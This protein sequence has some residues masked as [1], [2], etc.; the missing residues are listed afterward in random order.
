MAPLATPLPLSQGAPPS[1]NPIAAVGTIADDLRDAVRGLV[2]A[3][4]DPAYDEVR[5]AHHVIVDQRPAAV[6]IP[7]DA[8][9]VSAT[10]RLA[11]AHGLRVSA[12]AGGHGA[13]SSMEDCILIR[14][15]DLR[16]IEVDPSS[17]RALVG[18]GVRWGE[19]HAV[20]AEHRLH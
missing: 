1:M 3:P 9:D 15:H 12:Q 2:A 17:G 10:V 16:A 14:T 11:A 8:D 19:L 6:V 20:S 7:A 5:S 13:T 18:A 4:G